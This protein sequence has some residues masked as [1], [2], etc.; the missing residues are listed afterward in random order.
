M[1][2]LVRVDPG[3]PVLDQGVILLDWFAADRSRSTVQYDK[4]ERPFLAGLSPSPLAM[5]LL[6]LG[7]A[8]FCVDKIARREDAPDYWTR[9]LELTLPV[10]DPHRWREV[11]PLLHEA[12]SFLSGDH[13]SVSFTASGE[14]K[15]PAIP[16]ADAGEVVALFSGGLDSLAGAIELLESGER[17]VLIGHHDSSLTDHTQ[18]E[19]FAR[20][21]GAYTPERVTQR[22]LLLR[23][24]TANAQ[25]ARPLPDRGRGREI[26]TRTRSLLFVSAGV[27]IANA[28][29]D[30]TPLYMPENGF[31]GVNVPLTAARVGSL[32]TRTTHPLFIQRV[33]GLLSGLGLEHPLI[34]PFRLATK[35]EL[36]ERSSRPDLLRALATVT[37]SCSH[38]EAAR[39]HHGRQGN[40]GYCYP[41]LVRR[42]SLHRLGLDDAGE[43]DRDALTDLPLLTRTDRKSGRDLRALLTRLGQTARV[44]D[45]LRNGRIP[46][47][48]THAF[49]DVYCRGREELRVWLTDGGS[50]HIRA[51]VD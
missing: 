36:L 21:V 11:A 13:W 14:T 43:Y 7:G 19:L 16:P 6:R 10:S 17:V 33:A 39:W 48:D 34:N 41:C 20:L 22:R 46:N 49:F 25:Q 45:V 27:A 5:D 23:P 50:S 35:G 2:F 1:R 18:T 42:A 40:C 38:P 51:R 29:G 12:L 28:L 15:E 31:I 47:G 4:P 44:T 8:V 24:A 9:E 37:I 3:E 32:S 30:R 26:T